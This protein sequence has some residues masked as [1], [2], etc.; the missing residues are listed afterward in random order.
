MEDY[1]KEKRK[2]PEGLNEEENEIWQKVN[3]M[4]DSEF[5]SFDLIPL[6]R[7]DEIQNKKRAFGR[8][9]KRKNI[10]SGKYLLWHRLIGS[11]VPEGDLKLEL[12][13]PDHDIE[14]FIKKL[15]AEYKNK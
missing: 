2:V 8:E 9:L 12:D 7:I 6:E 1:Q 3:G 14:N 5:L 13:T 15:Y 11:S 10:D 4:L